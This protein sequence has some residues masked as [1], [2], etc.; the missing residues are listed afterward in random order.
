M[1][2]IKIYTDGAC[3]GN[4][5]NGGWGVYILNGEERDEIFGGKTV[6]TNNE[7]ELTASI[8]GLE[9]FSNSS[10]IELFTDSK[11]VMDGITS[12]IHNW[13]KNGWKTASKKPVKNSS[14]W[15]EL[16]KLNSFHD[17]NWNWVKGH[18]GDE[19]NDMADKLANQGIDNL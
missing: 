8:K 19:G 10:K 6:T 18:S 15:A 1:E 12:W 13:K 11:Y 2:I 9:Y 3:R 5:G 17:V 14:L 16:D 4:P 7:M